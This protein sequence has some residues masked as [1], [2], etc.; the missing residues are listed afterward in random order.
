MSESLPEFR[1]HPDPVAT[2]SIVESEESCRC[3]GNQRGFIYTGPVYALGQGDRELCPWCISDGSAAAMFDASFTDVALGFQDGVTVEV[4]EQVA[5]R[6]P[7]FIGWQQAHWLFH[8][9]DAAAFLGLAGY[10][11]LPVHEDAIESIRQEC[12]DVGLPGDKIDDYVENL[13][14]DG[15]ATAYLFKCLHCGRHLAYSDLS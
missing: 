12:R 10:A 7:G 4:I 1:Y 2:G 8:C 11:E 15:D 13:H 14:V 3:C 6:T 5:K 9:N